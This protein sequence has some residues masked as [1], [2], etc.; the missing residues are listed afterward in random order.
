[1]ESCFH[2]AIGKNSKYKIGYYVNPG[3]SIALHERDL[4]LLKKIQ[5][6]FG[7]I[8]VINKLKENMIQF[9]V[10]SIKD[11]E[12]IIN[13]FDLYPLISKKRA[14]FLLFKEAFKLIKNKEHLT[15]EGFNKIISI[16]AASFFKMQ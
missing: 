10:F 15:I 4:D 2:L 9:R 3:F 7:G 11:L 6:F 12:I 14:D 13:H 1:M 8:G 5:A 16:R